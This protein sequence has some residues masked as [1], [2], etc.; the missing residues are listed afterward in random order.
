MSTKTLFNSM[1]VSLAS[2]QLQSSWQW[3]SPVK[4]GGL[5]MNKDQ[6]RTLEL[7]STY[8]EQIP[9]QTELLLNPKYNGGLNEG[10]DRSRLRHSSVILYGYLLQLV[11]SQNNHDDN[12]RKYVIITGHDIQEIIGVTNSSPSGRSGLIANLSDFGLIERIAIKPGSPYHLYI[13]S[14]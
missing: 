10:T 6:N 13:N 8:G 9:V 5:C 1:E 11:N 3:T 14:I 2:H 12:D 7:K 4:L